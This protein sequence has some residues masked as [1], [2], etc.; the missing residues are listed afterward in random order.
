LTF[1]TEDATGGSTNHLTAAN[2]PAAYNIANGQWR[3]VVCVREGLKTSI[4]ID[5]VFTRS[6]NSGSGIKNVSNAGN[7]KIG[8][9]EN[10]VASYRNRY[11][12]AMDD[13]IIYRRAL[14]TQE[15]VDLNGL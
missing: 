12:G 7:F 2:S 1:A 15:I 6:V 9:Q 5:G 11:I 10:G 14:T 8:W 13:L 3:H 4:Y